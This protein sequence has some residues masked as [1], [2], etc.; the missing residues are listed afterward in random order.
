MI[1][2]QKKLTEIE[3]LEDVHIIFACESG[4]RAYGS[5]T[6]LSDHD[7][8]F[9]YYRD[10]KSYFRL[11]PKKDVIDISEKGFLEL[12]GWDLLKALDLFRK[13]NPT[14]YEMLHSP[15]VYKENVSLVMELRVLAAEWYSLRRM[16]FHYLNMTRTNTKKIIENKLEGKVLIKTLFQ[17]VR[18]LLAVTHIVNLN[19]LPPVKMVDLINLKPLENRDLFLKVLEVKR[20]ENIASTTFI[21]SLLEYIRT[22]QERLQHIIIDLP[23]QRIDEE[24]LNRLLW[25]QHGM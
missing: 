11:T 25:K 19:Q 20:N 5:D 13:S 22:E 24:V 7:V 2:I 1:P 12:H 23:D 17:A 16:S 9:I 14:L 21:P 8:K 10:I 6:S 15:I 4:S 18:A 3:K